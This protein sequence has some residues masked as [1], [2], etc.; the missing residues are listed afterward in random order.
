MRAKRKK[1]RPPS[2]LAF[3][4]SGL[5]RSARQAAMAKKMTKSLSLASLSE[6]GVAA[7]GFPNPGTHP[8]SVPICFVSGSP[9]VVGS[10]SVPGG[11]LPVPEQKHTPM[12][13]QALP[14]L[15]EASPNPRAPVFVCKVSASSSSV[16]AAGSGLSAGYMVSQSLPPVMEASP[17][18]VTASS[19]IASNGKVSASSAIASNQVQNYASLL[20]SSVQ[21]QAL[22][23]PSEHVSGAPFVLIPDE[24]IE[25]AKLEFKDFI[26]ARFHGDYPSMGKIIGVVNAVW[27]KTGPRIYVHNIG[28][29]I[30][31][32]RVSNPRA[33]EVLLSR[34]CWNIGGLP[35]FVAP[36]SPEYSRD[37]PPLTIGKPESLFPET[38]RK[39]NFA[40]AKLYVRVDLTTP[41]PHM[42]ISG[43]SNG[44]E[45]QIDVSYPWLPVKCDT[46][47]KFGHTKDKCSVQTQKN[48]Q[49]HSSPKKES[50]ETPRRRSKSRPGR[51]IDKKSKIVEAR[52]V[53]KLREGPLISDAK[54]N[55]IN[56]LTDQDQTTLEEGEINEDAVVVTAPNVN[57]TLVGFVESQTDSDE[58]ILQTEKDT[59]PLPIKNPI[60]S[61]AATNPTVDSTSPS[62]SQVTQTTPA[63]TPAI[64]DVVLPCYESNNAIVVG[65]FQTDSGTAL[66]V[67]S[68]DQSDIPP[69][70]GELEREKPF[71]LVK[72][73]K[74][75]R[76]V[77]NRH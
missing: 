31:L 51:S 12:V 18:K 16:S 49:E 38:E 4:V 3:K 10:A 35:M 68:T 75:G 15:L 14:L 69:S 47:K 7:I 23:S 53:P 39:D 29:G 45:V 42:I 19:T 64:P 24:N 40:V 30:Y 46:C 26:Y 74:S 13:Q 72:N 56:R 22:G 59:T 9:S 41:L 67:P 21:L 76:K 28:Q 50:S 27:A 65:D 32:L 17:N 5:M 70:A 6:I 36:W 54:E 58:Q 20:K 73:R 60:V 57:P 55:G 63:I 34:T 37:E 33:R 61:T 11:S 25:A 66:S 48:P 77:T 52:Y 44:K 62:R 2:A 1:A 71:F 8:S 43:F